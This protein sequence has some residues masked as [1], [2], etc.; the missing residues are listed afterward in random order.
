MSGEM[1]SWPSEWKDWNLQEIFDVS[2]EK[3][4]EGKLIG[5]VEADV[6]RT[7]DGFYCNCGFKYSTETS[8]ATLTTNVFRINVKRHIVGQKH[9]KN[10]R[11]MERIRSKKIKNRNTNDI[12][13]SNVSS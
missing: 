4:K 1:S 5:I 12:V 9:E 6:T 10:L 3:T 11:K 7:T 2:A 8:T 13:E